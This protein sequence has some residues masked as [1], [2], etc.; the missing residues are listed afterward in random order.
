MA[1]YFGTDPA[2]PSNVWQELRRLK[3]IFISHAHADHHA[4]LPK[5]L[6]MRK[7]LNPPPTEPLYLVS[8]LP[9]HLY[10]R[11][12]A[13]LEDLGLSDSTDT[14][15]GVISILS[16]VLNPRGRYYTAESRW[17]CLDHSR[18]AAQ[19]LCEALGFRTLNTV[20]VLHRTK[21]FGLVVTHQD[22]WRLVYSGDTMPSDA[23]AQAGEGATLLIHEATMGDDQEEMASAKAHSTISQAID[24]AKRMRAQNVLLTHFSSR[25][26][27]MPRYFAS[28]PERGGT[29]HQ[30]TIALAMDHACIRVGDLWKMAAYFPAIEQSFRDI[31]DEGDE[32][33]EVMLMKASMIQ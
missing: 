3:C 7:K 4:G 17:K 21:A 2:R 23:L 14:Q 30:P 24:V 8:I 29:D 15:N 5:I 22:G 28:S 12:L 16:D 10:L 32:E 31:T 19:M 11:D 13:H 9:I 18:K 20:N 33:E 6:A 26:P 1:R 25:Y 27:T